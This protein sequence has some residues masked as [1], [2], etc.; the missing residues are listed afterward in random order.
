[1][2]LHRPRDGAHGARSCP[3]L[4]HC[5]ERRLAQ[6]LVRRQAEVIVRCQV[7]DLFSVKRA[8]GLLLAFEDSQLRRH[9]LGPQ[10]VELLGYVLERVLFRG[11][12]GS[13]GHEGTLLLE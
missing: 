8:Y 6:R 12:R 3:I 1:M 11:L 7:D 4:P 13:F 9:P 5:L 2:Q 10:L